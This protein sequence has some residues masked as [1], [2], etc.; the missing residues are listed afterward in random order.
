MTLRRRHLSV[1]LTCLT[2]LA[3]LG[4]VPALFADSVETSPETSPAESYF[5]N[6]ELVN[7][8]GEPMRLYRDL[9]KDKIVVINAIFTTCSGVCPVMGTALK[10]IQERVGDRLGEDVHL[11]SISLD[12][13]VDTPEKLKAYADRFGARPGWY[14]L[15]GKT[16]NV[17][18]AL[19][20]LGQ[21]VEE[22]ETHNA[23]ILV[24]NNKTGLWKKAFGLADKSEIVAIVD[25]VLEDEG[26]GS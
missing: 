4:S 24:G 1:A 10:T 8:N 9:M 15:T 13:E 3:L 26:A 19:K 25:S 14:F 17:E 11:I 20:K 6:V 21:Y 5:T 23:I 18:F 22:K 7:Q 12:P 16:D 2:L